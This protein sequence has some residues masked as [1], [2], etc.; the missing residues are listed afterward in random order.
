MMLIPLVAQSKVLNEVTVNDDDYLLLSVQVDGDSTGNSVDAYLFKDTMLIAVEPLFSGLNLRY[1]L[2]EKSLIIWK[3]EEQFEFELIA[4]LPNTNTDIWAND[5]Y[6][7]YISEDLLAELFAVN[8]VLN[9]SKLLLKI[10]TSNYQFPITIIEQQRQQRFK[11]KLLSQPLTKRNNNQ[12]TPITVKDQYHLATLPHGEIFTSYDVSEDSSLLSTNLQLTSDLLY[13]SAR[14]NLSKTSGKDLSGGINLSRYKASPEDFIL[15]VF[16]YYTIGD[17]SSYSSGT[18]LEGSSGVGMSVQRAPVRYRQSNTLIDIEQQVPPGWET[19]LF[20]NNRLVSSASVPDT[21]LLVFTDVDI[22]YGRND[23]VIK[24]YGPFGETE[25]YNQS[26]PLKANPLAAGEMAYGFYA[27]D[28]QRNLLTNNDDLSSFKLDS[29]GGAFNYGINDFWQL[30]TAFQN[31]YDIEKE[32]YTQLLGLKNFFS[33]PGFLIETDFAT[34]NESDYAFTSN[35]T[36]RLFNT[37]AFQVEFESVDG[38]DVSISSRAEKYTSLSASYSD[39]VFNLP[40]RL[41]TSYYKTDTTTTAA[42][43]N[44]LFYNFKRLR[45]NHQLSLSYLVSDI[46]GL[47]TSNSSINGSLGISGIAYR[48]LRLSATINYN[49]ESDDPIL[50]SSRITAQYRLTDPFDLKHYFTLNYQPLSE[51]SD[52]RLSHNLAFETPDYRLS[53]NSNYNSNNN[54][55]F[56]LRVNFFLGYDYYNNVARTSSNISGQTATLNIHTYLD[57]QLNGIPDVLDYPLENVEFSGNQYWQEM[58]SGKTGRILLPGA[59]VNDPFRFGATW[60]DGSQT[61]NNDYVVYTH[62]GARIDI[63]MPF[64]L[65]T[66]LSG[67]VYKDVRQGEIPVSNLS[68]VMLNDKQEIVMQTNTDQ[69]GYFQFLNITPNQYE[70]AIDQQDMH[71]KALTAD[72]KGFSLTTPNNGGYTELPVLYVR[73]QTNENELAEESIAK[74]ELNEDNIEVL[75][76]D[77]DEKKRRNYFTLP[78]DNAIKAPY[79]LSK[80]QTAKDEIIASETTE[81]INTSDNNSEPQTVF[82]EAPPLALNNSLK[83]LPSLRFDNG[84]LTKWYTL[85]LGAFLNLEVAEQYTTQLSSQLLTELVIVPTQN[86]QMQTVY[87]IIY[88][89]FESVQLATT[90]ARMAL[91]SQNDFMVKPLSEVGYQLITDKIKQDMSPD[92]PLNS[93]PQIILSS[94]DDSEIALENWVIQFYASKGVI[95]DIIVSEFSA[96]TE[97]YQAEKSTGTSNETLN[98]LI[99]QGFANRGEAQQ[100]LIT[101]GLRGWVNTSAT[102]RNVKRVN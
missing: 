81:I 48:D 33:F 36:G 40:L 12:F 73:Q 8:M 94:I 44:L 67:F 57:R 93:S 85:Q 41:R 25:E 37:G 43:T 27:L 101:S 65:S 28:N 5:G 26:F 74:L 68:M 98:C 46:G 30:G 29:I 21:G 63:N 56:G 24:A 39:S 9:T 86:K 49:P 7:Q 99:S 102:Y 100:A 53:F 13:H 91:I 71:N 97:L 89:S 1:Q 14:I 60:Q 11:N 23:F 84:T 77:K 17:I 18:I 76:W 87:K 47:S 83:S 59:R 51:K 78:T 35:L 92:I 64:Y 2:R 58:R 10:E 80:N 88:G 34:N 16:D 42:L 52:W 90:S 6:Y 79:V 3:N 50:D 61:I 15:G 70:V 75:V 72:V 38:L 55:S 31:I 96:I 20:L 19:E 22:F 45:F 82:I 62:P 32:E 66:E 4:G 95:S 54:W 69:D